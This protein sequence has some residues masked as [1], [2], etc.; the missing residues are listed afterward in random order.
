[1][2]FVLGTAE[3]F[4][5]SASSTL[6]PSLVARTLALTI[7]ALNISFGLRGVG[8]LVRYAGERG[9]TRR[10]LTCKSGHLQ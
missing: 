4:A 9:P 10:Q 2:L 5:N 6:L 3:T 8:V 7:V 1:V